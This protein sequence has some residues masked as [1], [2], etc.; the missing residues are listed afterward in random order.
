MFS[1]DARGE[2]EEAS[3]VVSR[4]C[5]WPAHKE[6]ERVGELSRWVVSLWCGA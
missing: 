1:G 2:E 4:V 6:V 5:V 3:A